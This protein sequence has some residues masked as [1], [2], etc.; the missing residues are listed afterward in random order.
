MGYDQLNSLELQIR[1]AK[2][3]LREESNINYSILIKVVE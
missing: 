3:C 2:D 1:S